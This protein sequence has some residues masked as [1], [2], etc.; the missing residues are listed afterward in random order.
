[1]AVLFSSCVKREI[2]TGDTVTD[3]AQVQSK[4]KIQVNEAEV[5]RALT[6]AAKQ[7]LG[8]REGAVL[9]MDPHT[10]RLRAVV[11]PRLAFEQAF[12]PGS[13]IKSFTALTA[14][15][16]GL[17]DAESR[18]LCRGR[19]SGES[20]DV[21]C[22]HPKSKLPF[23][24]AQALAY[25]CNYFF[26][27]MSGRL[28]FDAFKGTLASAGL[29]ARTGVNA[30]ESAGV[31]RDGEWR[32]R[33][34]LGEGDNL[35]VTPIQLLTAYSALMNGGHLY[36][37]Q[38]AE[39]VGF[40][41]EEQ[42]TLHIDDP[43]RAALI[44]GMRGAVVYGTAE[45]S[46]LASLPIFIFGKTGTSTSSNGFRR[47]GWFVSFAADANSTAEATPESLELA[48]LVFVKRSHGSDAAAVSRRV[49]E[50]YA[51]TRVG[52]AATGRDDERKA[53]LAKFI[54]HFDGET[55][56][57]SLVTG[58]EEG[59]VPA[60]LFS[61]Q[62][63]DKSLFL[64]CDYLNAPEEPRGTFYRFA[65]YSAAVR[66]ADRSPTVRVKILSKNRVVHLSLEDYVL[67]VLSVE[68]AVEDQPEAL[69]AQAIITRTYALKNLG[70]HASEGFDL[71]SN[72]HCQQYAQRPASDKMR[73]AVTDTA[74]EVLRDANGQ[75]VDAYF[76]AACGGMTANIETLW[77]A[78]APSY[79]RGVRDD[80]CASMPNHEW[81]DVVPA[82]HLARALAG[83]PSTDVGRRIDDIVVTKRD[84]TGRAEI[85]AIEGERR[86]QVRGWEFKIVVGR[87]LG[88]NL[89]KSSRFVVSR[90]GSSFIFR[91]SG[92]GHGLG[93][94]QNGAHVM[95][96]RGAAYRQILDHYFPGTRISKDM[97]E[98]NRRAEAES[99]ID[100]GS[101][102]FEDTIK[103][104]PF[105]G[106]SQ[107][108][109]DEMVI[110]DA[111]LQRPGS[112]G[113]ECVVAFHSKFAS[114]HGRPFAP[115]E[116][117]RNT[118]RIPIKLSLLRS[119]RIP[120]NSTPSL[121]I[122]DSTLTSRLTLS[123]EHFH[124][125]YPATIPRSEI[126][127]VLRTLE[128][129]RLDMLA[130]AGPASLHLPDV[131]NV[132][133]HETTQDLVAATG[134]P[135][136]VAG[137][138]HGS[139]IEL[140]PIAV[141]HRRRVLSSTLRH[142]Y[143]HAVIEINGGG[144]T[145]RWLAEGLAISFAGEGPSLERF[146]PKGRLALDELER[147]LASPRSPAEMRSLYAAAYREVQALIKKEGE[148]SVWHRAAD[149]RIQTGIDRIYRIEK[150]VLLI[151]PVHPVYP[152]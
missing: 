53:R 150:P 127:A 95:A 139:G 58:R 148:S 113:A 81:T 83:D 47:Q 63:G 100:K 71:C 73:R 12:P 4:A 119:E 14:M 11:N 72:T 2:T 142:E 43:R 146:R 44:E 55:G 103:Y 21:V 92:F 108:R 114:K 132:V 101:E 77:G 9:V 50:E 152:C 3:K 74:G 25:S 10:G 89:L 104:I 35:L 98:Q 99:R 67:G 64:T 28:S 106:G 38:I 7:A 34:L 40:A 123:S 133:I 61:R 66:Y 110:V 121:P 87:A 24:L 48:V 85:I 56:Q 39:A 26:A 8:D 23:N 115:T 69:K 30:S 78:R 13:T 120:S 1:V 5:D 147:R 22:S 18:T 90:R 118:P 27:T 137:V 17:I 65:S 52:N 105:A 145:P 112:V 70:R 93:L 125:S 49:F 80:F 76:H 94:C 143:V 60:L 88:W 126:E 91:G 79:L 149:A 20:I 15:N 134:Q 138:T 6:A 41:G 131:T 122:L 32:V 31:L 16:A 116:L 97:N 129:S 107:S 29:G 45:K 151:H 141:L 86:R 140:Q 84:A 54:R 117:E 46:G 102:A 82:A 42:R 75:L 124:V 130:R 68:A 144:R 96:R 109:R 136:W 111:R 59:L 33:N 128:A 62:G 19:F 36:R 57:D 135:W 37:P 51:K